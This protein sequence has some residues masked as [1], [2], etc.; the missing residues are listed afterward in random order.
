MS[1][2][3]KRKITW[4]NAINRWIWLTVML[5]GLGW[6]GDLIILEGAGG[7]EIPW[8]INEADV[9]VGTSY[10]G[11]GLLA[12]PVR[13]TDG[14]IEVLDGP[15]VLADG[16][17]CELE[18]G[19][20]RNVTN[21]G[22]VYG[23][24]WSSCDGANIF[25]AAIWEE[26][27]SAWQALP[28]PPGATFNFSPIANAVGD[29]LIDSDVGWTLYKNNTFTPVNIPNGCAP[30]AMNNKNMIGGFC[31]D[32]AAVWYKGEQ[33][34]LPS[35]GP[36]SYVRGLNDKGT[37]VGFSGDDLGYSFPGWAVKWP[38]VETVE[39]VEYPDF[40]WATSVNNRGAIVGA[41]GVNGSE[42]NPLTPVW[43]DQH[44]QGPMYLTP[45]QQG[46]ARGIND[47]GTIIGDTLINDSSKA[48]VYYP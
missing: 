43:W 18:F 22:E 21:S 40:G 6:A 7:E 31:A 23:R 30:Y 8:A 14:V 19:D 20:P 41:I 45:G 37:L 32:D 26:D 1:N 33:T 27:S 16:T 28:L 48:F 34:I 38:D 17:E 12:A 13:W 4:R 46:V 42:L 10:G 24:V 3:P 36:Y 44:G 5:P 47:S 35:L 29:V 2:M 11:A 9:I 39:A 25:R 15:I